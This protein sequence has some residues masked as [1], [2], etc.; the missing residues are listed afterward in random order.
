M[1]Y[2]GT[3]GSSNAL[4]SSGAAQKRVSIVINNYNYRPFVRQAIE[5]A[6]TQTYQ[7]IE[8]IVVDDGSTDGSVDLIKEYAD[9]ATVI[10]KENGGQAS[11]FNVGVTRATGDLVLLLDSDDYLFPNAVE[12]CVSQFP[13]GYSRV[14]FRL[15]VV[16]AQGNPM[17]GSR[18]ALPF[19]EFDGSAIAAAAEGIGFPS[20]PTSGNVFD[21]RQLKAILPIPEDEYRICADAFVLIQTAV[22]GPVRSVDQELGAYRVHGGNQYTEKAPQLLLDRKR[23]ARH[24][25]NYFKTTKLIEQACIDSGLPHL[26]HREATERTF[27]PLHMLC[28]GYANEVESPHLSTWT[29][30]SLTRSIA[31]YLKS[32]DAVGPKRLPQALYLLS[33]VWMPRRAGGYLMRLMDEWQRRE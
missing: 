16:D 22:T 30:K 31:R 20:V 17:L 12:T 28:A 7:N 8:V 29:R 9:R 1:N 14:F 33:V 13:D 18:V 10:L 27:Y 2:T 4:G 11:A 24:I 21:A 3:D 6:L 23:L 25:D 19:M 32:G 5:S 15:C 26:N